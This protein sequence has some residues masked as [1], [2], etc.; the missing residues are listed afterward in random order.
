[1]Y[2]LRVVVCA[3]HWI[4]KGRL[5]S[6]FHVTGFLNT[7]INHLLSSLALFTYRNVKNNWILEFGMKWKRS[8]C[9]Y[10]G[11]RPFIDDRNKCDV[12]SVFPFLR[13]PIIS[14]APS[15]L[16]ILI[17][18][19]ARFYI[20]HLVTVVRH[21]TSGWLN[22]LLDWYSSRV[23]TV[24]VGSNMTFYAVINIRKG[25]TKVSLWNWPEMVILCCV[26]CVW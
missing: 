1:M 4:I 25:C 18:T 11:T 26:R 12:S 2:V 7:R 13:F 21:S 22:Q 14:L 16:V 9:V 20:W 24:M 17:L 6:H 23:V 10:Q 8:H 15:I 19:F 5:T 3:A